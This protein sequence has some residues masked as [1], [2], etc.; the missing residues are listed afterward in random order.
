MI[1]SAIITTVVAALTGLG[2]TWLGAYLNR[3]SAVDTAHKLVEVERHKYAQ[4]RLWDAKK[5]AYT[6]IVVQLNAIDRDLSSMESTLFDPDVDPTYY[7]ESEHYSSDA[8]A[9]WRRVGKL[10]A[11]LSDNSLILSDEF[12]SAVTDWNIDFADYDEDTQPR[13]VFTVQSEA[14]ARHKPVIIKIAKDE[15]AEA[16]KG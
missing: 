15:L 1:D 2:G 13:E 3:K 16:L 14:T 8:S 11:T 7:I 4:S 9:L 6:E 5:D 10:N 12:Q